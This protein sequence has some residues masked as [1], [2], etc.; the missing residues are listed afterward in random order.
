ME[1]GTINCPMCGAATSTDAPQCQYCEAQ[2][3]TVSCPSC[4]AMMFVGSKHCPRCGAAAAR[5]GSSVSPNRKCPR[6]KID[7]QVVNIGN[8]QVLECASCLGLWLTTGAFEKICGD[9]EQHAAVLGH[10]SLADVDRT[11]APSTKVNYVPCPECSQLMNRANFARCSGVI[12]DF[13]KKH[14]IWF[15]R[16]EL[17]RIVEFIRAG[18]MEISRA[19]EKTALEEERRKLH[20]EKLAFDMQ[21]SRAM[22]FDSDRV[23][24]IASTSSLLKL[25]LG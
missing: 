10:A 1:A 6:C 12:I 24:G 14:G 23:S 17:S 8:S 15:D 20:E 19:K 18:G 3:A 16:N 11:T 9:K 2:L 25:L 13:C 22:D 21:R 7:M 5:E 4:F